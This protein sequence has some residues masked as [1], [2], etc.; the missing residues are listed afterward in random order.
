MQ[1]RSRY[2]RIFFALLF[3]TFSV[4]THSATQIMTLDKLEAREAAALSKRFDISRPNNIR[5]VIANEDP[6]DDCCSCFCPSNHS[7]RN[8]T[9]NARKTESDCFTTFLTLSFF[10]AR[11]VVPPILAE[12]SNQSDKM[13]FAS[14]VVNSICFISTCYD[15]YKDYQRSQT[16]YSCESL[17][18]LLL[19]AAATCSW[20]YIF[21]DDTNDFRNANFGTTL[22]SGGIR[23]IMALQLIRRS[24]DAQTN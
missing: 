17:N 22:A 21:L 10:A 8:T 23:F 19:A 12:L 4:H 11:T 9:A 1:F 3:C 2:V 24:Y 5:I 6:D 14:S 15:A 7:Q 20:L 18:T 13:A 16:I